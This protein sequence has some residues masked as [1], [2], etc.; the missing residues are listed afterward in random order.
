VLVHHL[1]VARPARGQRCRP[2]LRPGCSRCKEA[3]RSRTAPRGRR[4]ARLHMLEHMRCPTRQ[5][6]Q[7]APAT[8]TPATA[9]AAAAGGAHR[10]WASSSC[11]PC[12]WPR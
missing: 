11:R 5:P 4:P 2:P 1:R 12:T 9:A 3:A 7:P 10:R 8:A 6:A